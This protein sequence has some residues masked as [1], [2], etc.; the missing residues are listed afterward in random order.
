MSRS[1]QSVCFLLSE[2]TES[3]LDQALLV[4]WLMDFG[5]SLGLG[6]GLGLGSSLS[7][8]LRLLV[9][10]VVVSGRLLLVL[11]NISVT[12]LSRKKN[13]IEIID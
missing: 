4:G 13:L 7:L 1:G 3:F 12:K 5:L 10:V 2:S 9:V 6:L 11:P 8:S